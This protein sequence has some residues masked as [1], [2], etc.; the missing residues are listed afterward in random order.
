H[1]SKVI[2]SELYRADLFVPG[3]EHRRVIRAQFIKAD[4][5]SLE[6][7][8]HAYRSLRNPRYV[9]FRFVRQLEVFRQD[10]GPFVLLRN[11][12]H[13]I[14]AWRH[15]LI[16]KRHRIAEPD[17]GRRICTGSPD[18]VPWH[19]AAKDLTLILIRPGI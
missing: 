7:F 19:K 11:R 4:G 14:L 5:E 3:Q 6:L 8:G 15:F 17:L 16:A 18:F 10:D 9:S 12:E 13:R 2:R 1:F